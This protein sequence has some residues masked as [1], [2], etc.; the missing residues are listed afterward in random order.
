MQKN[1]L[2]HGK[3]LIEQNYSQLYV[4]A[5]MGHLLVGTAENVEDYMRELYPDNYLAGSDVTTKHSPFP[6]NQA[7]LRKAF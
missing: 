5:A 1:I 3:K 2:E 7:L 4:M 6:K